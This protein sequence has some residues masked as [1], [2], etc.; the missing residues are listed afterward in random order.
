MD[1]EEKTIFSKARNAG[2]DLVALGYELQA[3]KDELGADDEAI[4]AVAL[5]AR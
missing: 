1:E 2:L 5:A 4:D 3:R